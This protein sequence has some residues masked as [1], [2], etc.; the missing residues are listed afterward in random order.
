M[1]LKHKVCDSCRGLRVSVHTPVRF[2]QSCHI[3]MGRQSPCVHTK[4]SLVES[5]GEEGERGH[6]F[7]LPPCQALH[8][9][10][11]ASLPS[12][13][14]SP[15]QM[16]GEA[17]PC[18]QHCLPGDCLGAPSAP[19]STVAPTAVAEDRSLPLCF[20]TLCQETPII[21]P[22]ICWLYCAA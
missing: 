10:A 15:G 9:L 6:P 8:H 4:Y 21:T 17:M 12:R 2:K 14:P 7:P 3:P 20:P 19:S 16:L 13:L 5:K 11:A 18:Q 1:Q 22:K